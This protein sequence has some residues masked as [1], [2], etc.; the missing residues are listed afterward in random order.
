MAHH[1]LLVTVSQM[2]VSGDDPSTVGELQATASGEEVLLAPY[3]QGTLWLARLTRLASLVPPKAEVLWW[4][5]ATLLCL[6]GGSE[7]G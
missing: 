1:L 4:H 6:H 5:S 3:L 2:L 7:P